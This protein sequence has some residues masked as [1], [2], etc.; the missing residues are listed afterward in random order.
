[1]TALPQKQLGKVIRGELRLLCG[2][3]RRDPV[4]NLE[5]RNG[6]GLV[7]ITERPLNGSGRCLDPNNT[8][9]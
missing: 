7:T 1:M 3:L 4:G 8:A 2:F 5:P 9:G 6:R